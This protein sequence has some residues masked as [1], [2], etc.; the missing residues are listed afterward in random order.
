MKNSLRA[1]VGSEDSEKHAHQISYVQLIYRALKEI[2]VD[3][4]YR[5]YPGN[6]IA[7]YRV[8]NLLKLLQRRFLWISY[9]GLL[10]L[11]LQ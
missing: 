9:L 10:I 11:G 3:D 4:I 2:L 5:P 1:A 6:R 7:S 8:D